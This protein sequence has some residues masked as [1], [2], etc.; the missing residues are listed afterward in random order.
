MCTVEQKILRQE[1]FVNFTGR[2]VKL[3]SVNILLLSSTLFIVNSNTIVYCCRGREDKDN[4]K[5]AS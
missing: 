2:L 3:L 4:E 1:M 5:G